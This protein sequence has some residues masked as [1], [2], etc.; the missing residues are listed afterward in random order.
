[1]H[2]HVVTLFAAL[3]VAATALAQ[4][5]DPNLARN[6][7]AACAGCHG[8]QGVSKGGVPSLAGTPKAELVRKLADFKGGRAPGT[9]MPQLAR[10]YTDEQIDLMAGWFA[11]QK[12]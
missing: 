2:R 4:P 8:T 9:V 11:A 7:A 10:G 6:L 12:P 3:A 1:M 5:S